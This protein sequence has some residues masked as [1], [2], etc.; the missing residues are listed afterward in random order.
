[1]FKNLSVSKKLGLFTGAILAIILFIGI[2]AEII[3][4]NLSKR[5]SSLAH[6][7]LPSM[8]KMVL[9]DMMHDGIRAN[10]LSSALYSNGIEVNTAE[11]I[12][13]ELKD[14]TTNMNN[15]MSEINALPLSSDIKLAIEPVLPKIEFYIQQAEL[16][17]QIALTKNKAKVLAKMPEFNN[18][19]E[20]L[21]LVLG[22]LGELIESDAQVYDKE[23]T[24]FAK[25]AELINYGL[26]IFG[27]VFGLLASW[28][29]I[30]QLNK[31]LREVITK[32]SDT[33]DDVTKSISKLDQSAQKL[34]SVATE[35]SAAIEESVASM[36]EMTAMISQT[37]NNSKNSQQIA[38]E[39]SEEASTGAKIISEM[40]TAMDEIYQNTANL[41]K[42]VNLIHEIESKTKVIND[43]VFE[44]RLLSFNASIEAARAGTHGKGFAVVA[45]E[46]GKLA[47]MSGK[48]AD[49]IR[50][51]LE[52]TTKEVTQTVSITQERVKFGK[53]VSTQCSDSFK[54]MQETIFKI[55]QIIGNISTANQEQELGVKQNQKAMTELERHTQD[56]SQNSNLL[57]GE[58]NHLSKSSTLLMQSVHSMQNLVGGKNKNKT[59]NTPQTPSSSS[60]IKVSE[61]ALIK[62]LEPKNRNSNFWRKSA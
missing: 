54:K 36:E 50:L 61:N 57:A 42:M 3:T 41:E 21:E 18:A 39:C 8:H 9:L 17:V 2:T 20:E 27:F 35:Q 7:K 24:T 52:S 55:E 1:M 16:I 59:E 22:K 25:N 30:S 4:Q 56:N 47:S 48:A 46:V 10:V 45:E 23:S 58:A 14:F 62:K 6:E 44:T 15:F 53:N 5:I 31:Q 32:L 19:F 40:V 12:Q 51:L 13:S 29:V 33:S 49:E 34:S 43:I 28:L 60:E 38:S 26:I 11:E 37:A